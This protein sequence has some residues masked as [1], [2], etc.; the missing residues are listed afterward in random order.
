MFLLGRRSM[1]TAWLDL[2]KNLVGRGGKKKK[3]FVSV[4]ARHD[5]KA[6]TR[7]YEMLS[8]ENST[9][10][11]SAS[12]VKYPSTDRQTSA[13]YEQDSAR[14]HAPSRSFSTTRSPA[15]RSWDAQQTFA[16][17]RGPSSPPPTLSSRGPHSPPTFNSR[18]PHSPSPTFNSPRGPH[19]PPPT[20]NSRGPH[21][22]PPTF[23]NSRAPNS[24]PPPPRSPRS[25]QP[26]FD[27]RS[28]ADNYESMNPLGMNRI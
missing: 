21:S 12:A 2:F 16:N 26:G 17:T 27:H 6:D 24:P 20:F 13:H 23:A 5:M 10:V 15:Q 4:D 22:P 8:R 3:E 7:S 18:G 1:L 14:Y 11:T 9:V 25:P 19:S 28:H